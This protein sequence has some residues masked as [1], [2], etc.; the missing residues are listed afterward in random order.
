MET[1]M[2]K[3]ITAEKSNRSSLPSGTNGK[4][5]QRQRSIHGVDSPV[6]RTARVKINLYIKCPA[7]CIAR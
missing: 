7:G 1:T 6:S 3:N 4:C 5:T 2:E